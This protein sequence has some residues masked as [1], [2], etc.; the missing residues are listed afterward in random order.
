MPDA[1]LLMIVYPCFLIPD[2]NFDNLKFWSYKAIPKT[3]SKSQSLKCET[4]IYYCYM[5]YL[6]ITV[7]IKGKYV[8]EK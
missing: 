1:Y 3:I 8:Y 6:R 7:C 5:C 4:L 2:N